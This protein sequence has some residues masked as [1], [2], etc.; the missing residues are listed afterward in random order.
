MYC[1]KGISINACLALL[2]ALLALPDRIQ[3]GDSGTSDR[4]SDI[5][6]NIPSTDITLPTFAPFSEADGDLGVQLIMQ[7]ALS[8][9][10]FSVSVDVGYLYTDNARVSQSDAVDDHVF[11]AGLSMSYIPILYKNLYG[12]V[13]VQDTTFNY[14]SNSDLDFNDFEAGAGL[15]YVF[16]QLGDTT[17][18][19]RYNF[20]RFLDLFSGLDD[21]YTNHS[22]QIGAYKSWYFTS[23]QHA[24]I[25][26][27][28]DFSLQ[29]TPQQATRDEHSV[30][31]AYRLLPLP[32]LKIEAYYRGGY[33]DFTGIDRSDFT[34]TSGL[35]ATWSFTRHLYAS[36][37]T[38][39]TWNDSDALERDYEVFLS[40]V[41]VGFNYEF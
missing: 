15:L 35:A 27:L 24:Y 26:F 21:I 38:S 11:T 28:S 17:L 7:P 22:I 9:D 31:L 40:G 1:Q 23:R 20:A 10:A 16:R 2:V 13:T 34:H 32:K 33:L 14:D 41:Q 29:G 25:A 39:Y 5:E 12:E 19:A 3:A 4:V 37:H 18:V 30:I 36:V 6:S 8:Y